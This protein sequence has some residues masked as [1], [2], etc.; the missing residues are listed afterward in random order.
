MKTKIVQITAIDASMNNMLKLLNERSKEAG[1]E[2]HCICSPGKN[3]EKIINK[4]YI[5]HPV[6]IDRKIAPISNLKSIVRIYKILKRIKPDIVHVHTPVA[7][8]LGRI[9]ARLANVDNIIYTAHG[10]YFHEGMSARKYKIFFN[11]EKY[12]GKFFTDFIFTQSMEDYNTAKDNKFLKNEKNYL[13]ISNGI[14]L[15]KKFN[16][17]LMNKNTMTELKERLGIKSEDIVLA[18][19][20]RLVKE[21]GILDLLEA[22]KNLEGKI[23]TKL[24]I[25]GNIPESER[26]QTLSSTINELILNP[27]IIFTGR[28]TNVED[29]LYMSDIFIL[30]S[31]REGMPR[32]IIEAMAMKNAIIATDIRGSREEVDD[33]INGFLVNLN[34][35]IEIEEKIIKLYNNKKLL[36][37]MQEAAYQKAQTEY[38]EEK[39][40]KKQLQIFNHC[41]S[42]WNRRKL[43][44]Q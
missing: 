28:V 5:Y 20:G 36:F 18:Y 27:N 19:V 24:L 38:D 11:I 31:F 10:F 30:P 37:D 17:Q 15:T 13:H 39:V 43:S 35:P 29:Y 34:S 22:F 6:N 40:V 32:S 2:V 9:A 1:Y 3:T 23:N 7:A 41:L 44:E 21:K 42:K 26:D 12:M 33:N 25:V 16:Y 4:G 14:D 8:V